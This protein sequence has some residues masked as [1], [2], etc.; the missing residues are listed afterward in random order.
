MN[1]RTFTIAD[2]GQS[3]TC[4]A[5]GRTSHN[6]NDVKE[7]YCGHCNVFHENPLRGADLRDIFRLM[8][9]LQEG[10]RSHPEHGQ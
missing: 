3:I 1:A 6:P 2:D 8:E 9:V 4:H 7:R 10:R 5:C